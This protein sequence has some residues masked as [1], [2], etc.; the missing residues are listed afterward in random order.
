MV[1]NTKIEWATHTFNPWVGCQKVGPGCDHCYAEVAND[2]A[3]AAKWGPHAERVRTKPRNWNMPMKWDRAA[4]EAGERHRVFCSSLADVFDNHRSV[5]PEWRADLA[6]LILAT[7]HLD[8]LLLTKRIGNADRM[9]REMFPEGTPSN[10]WVGVTITSQAEAGRDIPKLIDL[11]S[12]HNLSVAYLSME[13]LLGPVDL[14]NLP[15]PSGLENS[16]LDAL[17]GRFWMKPE[18][19][20]WSVPVGA[21]VDGRTYVNLCGW[22]DWVIVGGETGAK[23]RPMH[24]DWVRGLRD[25][26]AAAGTAFLFKQWGNWFPF[27]EVDARG[28]QSTVSNGKKPGLWH[29]W[30][31][32]GGF[33]VIMDK[34]DAGR[35]LDGRTWDAVPAGAG[36]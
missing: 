16:R 14:T 36:A 8:W 21:T 28:F 25:Q 30:A 11:K 17:R 23:P 9:L 29:E 27:G 33:S 3:H 4:A 2:G 12:E 32:E 13:P 10:I 15:D 34:R 24:I 5:L 20:T 6:E 7:P 35:G 26:C 1:E 22:I 19:V 18:H 31:E